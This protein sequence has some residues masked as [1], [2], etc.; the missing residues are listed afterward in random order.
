MKKIIN[1]DYWRIHDRFGCLDKNHSKIAE[2]N[3]GKRK[4][5]ELGRGEIIL[6]LQIFLTSSKLLTSTSLFSLGTNGAQYYF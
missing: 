6:Y 3:P 1:F 2:C 4:I 5:I